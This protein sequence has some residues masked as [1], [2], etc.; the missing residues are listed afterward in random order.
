MWSAS[1]QIVAAVVLSG[2]SALIVAAYVAASRAEVDGTTEVAAFVV[3]AAGLV[4]GMHEFRLASAT[5]A[6][7]TLLLVEKSKLHSLVER[8]GDATLRAAFR[9]AVMAVVVLPLLPPG[10][11]GPLGGI[12]PRQLWAMVLLFSGLS[13]AGYLARR[14]IGPD[15]G[16]PIAG[17]IGGIISSTNV[18]L[19]FAR[20]SRNEAGASMPLASGVMAANAVMCLRV[21]VATAVLNP[22]VS[23]ALAPYLIAPFLVAAAIAWFG[24]RKQKEQASGEM[25]APNNPLQFKLA[26]EMAVLFQLVLFGVRWAKNTWGDPG[27]FVSAGLVG[28]TDVDALVVSMAKDT[29]AQL[30][31]P[32]AARAIVVG[33]LANTLLKLAIGV[34]LGARE[35]R[36][37]V[38]V[39]LSAV[40]IACAAS[41][42]WI[43]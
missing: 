39:G 7:T 27:V 30:P 37:V 29:G 15:R 19:S 16:Y 12:R 28:L 35:F 1:L 2:I 36:K 43:R 21:I 31:A 40:A 26:L 33:V 34:G 3:L 42:L 4:A 20:A 10:P 38:F 32:I 9:F 14:A 13:F 5:I 23:I 41:L 6:I 11:F 8:I 17:M 22:S 24:F 25:P 18:T